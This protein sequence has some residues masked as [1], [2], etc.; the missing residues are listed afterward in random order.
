MW[1]NKYT[2][3]KHSDCRIHRL[4]HCRGVRPLTNEC[5]GN[6]AKKSDSMALTFEIWGKWSTFSWPLFPGPLW[7]RVVTPVKVF[8][9]GQ[10]E[11]TNETYRA[12]L[13]TI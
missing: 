6:D 2:W 4:H 1:L 11:Q 13:E 9:I 3:P 7:P 12:I 8:L 10:I 5:S